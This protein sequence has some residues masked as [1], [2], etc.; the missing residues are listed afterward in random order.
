MIFIDWIIVDPRRFKAY[1][2]NRVSE[3][4]ELVPP[5][6]WQHVSGNKNPADY[7]SRGLLPSD[8]LEHSM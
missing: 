6:Y 8:H 7:A 3:I 4:A 1:V 5:D 2:G